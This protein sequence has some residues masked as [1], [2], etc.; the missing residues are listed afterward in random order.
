MANE[1][2]KIIKT[3]DHKEWL[4]GSPLKIEQSRL[5]WV[6]Q[7]GKTI[8]QLELFNLSDMTI[9]SVFLDIDCFNEAAA[10]PVS[11][12]DYAILGVNAAPHTHFSEREPVILEPA[13]TTSVKIIISKVVFADGSLWRNDAKSPGVVLPEQ[14][15]I[16]FRH[17][18][19]GQIVRECNLKGI[20]H[21]YWFGESDNY[22]RCTCGQANERDALQCGYCKADKQWLRQH[23]NEKYLSE[24]NARFVAAEQK[25][26][27]WLQERAAAAT[28]KKQAGF[29]KAFTSV[30][31][32]CIAIAVFLGWATD[33]TYSYQYYK[34][35]QLKGSA[36]QGAQL[37]ST[38][39]SND[40]NA[41]ITL[42]Q[43][44]VDLERTASGDDN[45]PSIETAQAG[46]EVSAQ[47]KPALNT[48]VEKG[49]IDSATQ[50]KQPDKS[51]QVS[52]AGNNNSQAAG[53]VSG[54]WPWTS[55]RK[56][57]EKDLLDLSAWKLNIMRNEVYARHGWNFEVQEFKSYFNSQPWY[58]PKKI[59]GDIASANEEVFKEMSEL[60]KD[61]AEFILNYQKQHGLFQA[62]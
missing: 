48:A 8:L 49:N 2:Y 58:K 24:A 3:S 26:H 39:L 30:C 15:A 23:L 1:R 54:R 16:D 55:E 40:N 25:R 11:I 61:N 21:D 6:S 4:A 14:K 42:N 28:K 44:A 17:P 38:G 10:S 45:A 57:L 62:D 46:N 51:N 35:K 59:T 27:N 52:Q 31:A 20:R 7:D 33:Y 19:F 29:F 32:V 37:V 36:E 9:K 60:E 53:K 34:S 47:E 43:L 13:K 50:S 22:W 18:L 56:V 5:V 41:A 12:N